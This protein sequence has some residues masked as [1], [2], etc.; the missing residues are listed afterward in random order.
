MPLPGA[1]RH[2]DAAAQR[3]DLGAHDVHADAAARDL[4]DL[5]RGREARLEDALDE[6]RVGGLRVGG[7]PA[8]RD[9]LARARCVEVEAG[10]VVGELDRDFVADLAHGQRDFAGLGLAGLARARRAARCRGRAR[11]AAGARA[12]R[13]AFPA[14]SGRARSARRGFRGSRA[15]RAPSRSRAGSGT[16]ARTGCRTARCGSRTAAAARRAT[17]APA[18]A[19]RRRRRR[20]S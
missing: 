2:L 10:A 1:R 18:R 9:R 15:C 6:L 16:G 8:L 20:G 13:R 4:R 19:A 3:G 11:C 17:A 14:P 5:R 12:G 7:D